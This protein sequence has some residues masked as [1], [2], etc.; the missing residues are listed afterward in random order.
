MLTAVKVNTKNTSIMLCCIYL[1]NFFIVNFE[2]VFA[3]WAQDKI[4]KAT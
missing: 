1:S 3:S 4:H 2:L